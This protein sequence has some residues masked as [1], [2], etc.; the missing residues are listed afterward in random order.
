MTVLATRGKVA[1]DGKDSSIEPGTA[2]IDG[3]LGGC[4]WHACQWPL[5]CPQRS[6]AIVVGLPAATVELGVAPAA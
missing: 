4:A 6:A 1:E 5:Y 2:A 3:M